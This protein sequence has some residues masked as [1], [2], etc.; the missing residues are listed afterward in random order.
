MAGDPAMVPLLL[1]LGVDELSCAPPLVPQIKK[2][3]RQIKQTEAEALVKQA[4]EC[5]S[6]TEIHALSQQLARKVAPTLF[7]DTK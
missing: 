6:G 4:F 3:V 1:G 2:L 5:D 7:N